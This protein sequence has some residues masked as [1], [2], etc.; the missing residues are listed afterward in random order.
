MKS[1]AQLSAKWK[2]AS[3]AAANRY[4]SRSK[5]IAV[6]CGALGDCQETFAEQN[7]SA[8]KGG[9]IGSALALPC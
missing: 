8:A 7:S 3:F 1:W 4:R 5:L 6:F 9:E 2:L